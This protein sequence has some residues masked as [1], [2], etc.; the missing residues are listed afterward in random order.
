M[1]TTLWIVSLIN[2]NS[3]CHL[4]QNMIR[5][6]KNVTFVKWVLVMYS[7]ACMYLHV[8]ANDSNF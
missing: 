8:G 2:V 1:L 7:Y 5:S 4:H 6:Q 3:S